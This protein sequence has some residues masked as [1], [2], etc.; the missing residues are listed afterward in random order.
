M[1]WLFRFIY[2]CLI[3]AG[4]LIVFRNTVLKY[5]TETV[6]KDIYKKHGW[7]ITFDKI[8]WKY[9]FFPAKVTFNDI[10]ISEKT[11]KRFTVNRIDVHVTL[12]SLKKF[13][14]KEYHLDY[15]DIYDLKI[16]SETSTKPSFLS[17]E[18]LMLL[19][20]NFEKQMGAMGVFSINLLKQIG[21][22]EEFTQGVAQ[23]KDL[24]TTTLSRGLNQFLEKNSKGY[25][26]KF[27]L[28]MKSILE[29]DLR[30]Y[31]DRLDIKD[32]WYKN[33]RFRLTLKDSHLNENIYKKSVDAK[34]V[35]FN[36]RLQ[37]LGQMDV[38]F[39][40]Q[41]E[42]EKWFNLN[43]TYKEDTAL[44]EGL[45]RS[46]GLS[47]SSFHLKKLEMDLSKE[48]NFKG[49]L[50][51]LVTIPALETLFKVDKN[52]TFSGT[53]DGHLP[54]AVVFKLTSKKYTK[55]GKPS[56]RKNPPSSKQ[57]NK[58]GIDLLLKGVLRSFLN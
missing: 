14:T 46:L 17:P 3:V 43:L 15:V 42:D 6:F 52:I 16:I 4:L 19:N 44:E 25:Y 7:D 54:K 56:P 33:L 1:R 57:D 18:L 48:G 12:E 53:F 26:E 24:L 58:S 34:V 38:F 39:S 45:F 27:D 55:T 32:I 49:D 13:L 36:Q 29:K 23:T 10:A 11:Q 31:V 8:Y 22:L 2:L 41:K 47:H 28:T 20:G 35:I 40:P 21:K 30:L 5:A 37:E 9:P 50:S 51:L